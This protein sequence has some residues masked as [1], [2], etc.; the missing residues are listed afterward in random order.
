MA[1]MVWPFYLSKKRWSLGVDFIVFI[2]T[3]CL[4]LCHGGTNVKWG[5]WNTLKTEDLQDLWHE[6]PR[7]ARGIVW[8]SPSPLFDLKRGLTYGKA[9]YEIEKMLVQWSE[10]VC[11]WNPSLVANRQYCLKKIDDLVQQTVGGIFIEKHGCEIVG[12]NWQWQIDLINRIAFQVCPSLSF[13][14][15]DEEFMRCIP[16]SV[17]FELVDVMPDI[18]DMVRHGILKVR[19]RRMKIADYFKVEREFRIEVFKS[20][21]LA[22]ALKDVRCEIPDIPEPHLRD[23][24]LPRYLYIRMVD[25]NFPLNRASPIATLV[26][27]IYFSNH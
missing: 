18:E 11:K 19:R 23:G 2:V 22:R 8:G 27:M 26:K 5:K 17:F 9:L 10:D 7:I 21:I 14:Y 3:F 15:K 20:G 25:H 13:W 24:P 16:L 12:Y 1:G 6:L 4:C